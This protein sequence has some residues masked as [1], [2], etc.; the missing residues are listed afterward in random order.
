MELILSK[1]GIHVKESD[2]V[3]MNMTTSVPISFLL[4]D[5]DKGQYFGLEFCLYLILL[6][7]CFELPS[8]TT[9]PYCYHCKLVLAS[10][11]STRQEFKSGT[12]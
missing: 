10:D 8:F 9:Y 1:H 7:G 3:D 5:V 4:Y 6:L 12:L 2:V 11:S